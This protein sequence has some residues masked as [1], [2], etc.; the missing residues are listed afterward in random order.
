[1]KKLEKQQEKFKTVIEAMESGFETEKES[2]NK[3]IE[4]AKEAKPVTE[5]E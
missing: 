3:Q 2:L 4:D 5:V 1:M